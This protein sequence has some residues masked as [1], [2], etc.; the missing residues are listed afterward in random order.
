MV[1]RGKLNGAKCSTEAMGLAIR[2]VGRGAFH[3]QRRSTVRTAGADG[4]E[5]TGMSSEKICENHIRR[6]SKVSDARSIRVG[7]V[8]ALVE[9]ERRKRWISGQHS[10]TVWKE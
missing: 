8:R 2:Q 1:L 9:A 4:S 5:N 10:G 7:L 3:Q 6:M